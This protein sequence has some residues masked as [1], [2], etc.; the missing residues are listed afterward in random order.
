MNSPTKNR[1]ELQ[2]KSLRGFDFQH[3][4]REL[5]LLKYGEHGFT[6]LRDQKDKGC[7]GIIEEEKRVIA[8]YGPQEI[9]DTKKRHR[10]FDKKAE[11]DYNEF[12]SNWKAQY[13]NWSFVINHESDPHYD[14]KIKS[15]DDNATIIGLSQLMNS[16][17]NLKNFQRRKIGKYLNIENEYLSSDYIGEILEDLLKENDNLDDKISYKP[18]SLVEITDKIEINFD[19]N[20]IED[21]KNEYGLLLEEGILMEIANILY[22]YE[23][24][25]IS[26]IKRRVIHDYDSKPNGN[27]KSRLKSMTDHYLVKYSNENDDDYLFYIRAIL[28]YFFEQ[29]LIGKKTGT[30]I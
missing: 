6:V 4:V 3:F 27:F 12:N 30:E 9:I 18:K 5:Y 15:L 13:P 11:G 21:A 10:E 14:S 23:D 28:I 24:K 17:E 20:E 25:E 26:K 22:G 1:F 8:C 29:C 2:I 16:I 7:D 19:I